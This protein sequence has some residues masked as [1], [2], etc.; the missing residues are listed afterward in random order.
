MDDTRAQQK[1]AGSETRRHA[2]LEA[3]EGG[4]ERSERKPE[5]RD[6]HLVLKRRIGPADRA[7]RLLG[8]ELVADKC[9]QALQPKREDEQIAE[10][11]V[12]N[13]AAVDWT[14]PAP[15][16]NTGRSERRPKEQNWDQRD[17][18]HRR[19]IPPAP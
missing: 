14:R 3:P 5:I 19:P 8:K 11:P 6:S 17:L 12:D 9:L 2:R 1:A 7:R 16:G 15:H 10:Q 13:E 18:I 4:I